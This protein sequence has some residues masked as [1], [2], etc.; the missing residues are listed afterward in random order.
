MTSPAM[1]KVLSRRK[2]FA[3]G[4][5]A[6]IGVFAAGLGIPLAGFAISPITKKGEETWISIADVD[7]LKDGEPLQ[8]AYSY[9]RK[10]G[11]RT[12]EANKTA[13]ILRKADGTPIVLSNICTHL[14]C[15]VAWDAPAKQFVCPCHGGAFD[16]EGKVT[17]GP[18]PKPLPQLVAKVEQNKIYV[19]EA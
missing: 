14:G 13:F 16:A 19:R 12:V 17:G 10:D 9:T 4:I 18:P 11:W 6:V 1:G 2:F 15:A 3:N 7:Q 8:V 5:M